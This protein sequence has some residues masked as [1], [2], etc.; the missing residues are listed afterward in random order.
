[1]EWPQS[2][3]T[4]NIE[5]IHINEKMERSC[6]DEFSSFVA[7]LPIRC[8]GHKTAILNHHLW[9]VGGNN[10][11]KSSCKWWNSNVIYAMYIKSPYT[12]KVKC[13]LPKPLTYHGLEIV[14][15]NELLIIGGSTTGFIDDVVDTVLL[16]NTVTNTLRE[17]H[18]LP[19]PM[20][21]MATVK[22]GEDVI[23]IGGTNKD[24]E[25][26][27]TVFKYNYKKNRCEQLP[28]MKYK[29]S[30]CTA[31]ISGNKVFVMGGYNKEQGY[32]SSVECFDLDDQVWCDLPFM[33]EA[34][35]KIAAVLVP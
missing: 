15:D 1:M 29:R 6:P 28:G 9:M 8:A 27:N 17:M 35:N 18:P 16:Y 11:D 21:D 22:H 19:F 14:N 12:C 33:N 7:Q 2:Y 20:D 4:R 5:Y 3:Y 32:L 34:K 25:C 31:V 23:I 13:Q 24:G 30:E 10:Y 26:L